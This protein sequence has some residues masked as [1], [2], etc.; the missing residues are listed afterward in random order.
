M[1]VPPVVSKGED[2]VLVTVSTVPAEEELLV[3]NCGDQ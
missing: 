3:Q 2:V 1:F